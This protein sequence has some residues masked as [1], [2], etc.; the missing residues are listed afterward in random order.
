MRRA[1]LIGIAFAFAACGYARGP[2][3]DRAALPPPPRDAPNLGRLLYQ[4]DCAWCHGDRGEG[5]G[6][7]PDL[8]KGTNGP[9]LTDFVLRTRR[10]PLPDPNVAMRYG[11]ANVRYSEREIAAIESYVERFGAKGPKVEHPR[12]AQADL[13][14]GADLYLENCAACHSTTGIGGAITPGR[15][16]KAFQAAAGVVA[17]SLHRSDAIEV[18]EA[19]RTGPGAMPVFGKGTLSERDVDS[20]V[21]Y[22]LYLRR[23]DDR[24]GAATGRI[25]P[26][27]EGAVGWIVG[28]GALL[29]FSRFIGS[30]VSR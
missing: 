8:V 5:T 20:I 28:L 16:T 6:R 29:V 2:A 21:R 27:A 17:P 13:P 30:K 10:M 25:G 15:T 19:I 22:V 14:R 24:G 23:P 1:G 26:V 12:P 18:A 3:P 4:R 7:A 9:A 11:I